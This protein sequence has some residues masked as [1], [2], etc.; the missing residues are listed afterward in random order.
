MVPVWL[1]CAAGESHPNATALQER[2]AEMVPVPV[3]A[4]GMLAIQHALEKLAERGIT[5]VLIEGGP[6]MSRAFLDADLVDEAVVYQGARPAGEGALMPFAS[7]GLDRLT[8]SGDFKQIRS[9]TFGPDR[10]TWWR[11]NR[12]CSLALSAA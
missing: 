8:A 9:R 2:G 5:S 11:R 4:D 6:Q 1:V 3:D 12:K 10:M 7:D